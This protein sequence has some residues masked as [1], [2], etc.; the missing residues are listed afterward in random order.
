MWEPGDDRGG[1]PMGDPATLLTFVVT[2]LVGMAS[3]T[4]AEYVLHRFLMHEMRGRGL[5]SREHLS[6]HARVD[7][8]TS[9]QQKL[10]TAGATTAVVFPL[11]WIV[12]DAA[13]AAT[14]TTGFI[15]MYLIYEF[16][17]R[18]AHTS[19]P[20]SPY[21]RWLRKSHFAHHFKAPMKNHG[22]TSPVWD[23]VFGTYMKVDV[24][25]VPRRMATVWLLDESGAVLPEYRA[26]YQ[27]VGNARTDDDTRRRDTEDAFAKR[28]PVA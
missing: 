23:L 4:L 15:T 27:V 1:K 16:L 22:V 25:R 10:L 5:A 28:V 9:W 24:V 17:H 8:F 20:R 19:P 21:G 12:F 13:I 2:F 14:F 7:Y 18:R 11:L 26:G 6:H 3:W